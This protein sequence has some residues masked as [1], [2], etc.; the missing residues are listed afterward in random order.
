MCN[1][2]EDLPLLFLSTRKGTWPDPQVFDLQTHI[3]FGKITALMNPKE[4]LDSYCSE[5]GVFRGCS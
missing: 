5:Y 2:Q 1:R 3:F 4:S